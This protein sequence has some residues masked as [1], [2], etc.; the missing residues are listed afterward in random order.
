VADAR[1]AAGEAPGEA[2]VPARIIYATYGVGLTANSVAMMLKVV[3]PLWAIHLGLSATEIGMAVAASALLPFLLSIH[4]GVMMDRLGIR[5]VTLAY[6]VTTAVAAPFYPVLPFYST[7]ILLQLITG[8][9][10]NM[11]WVGGQ[12]LICT[13]TA[14]KTALLARFSVAGKVGTLAAPAAVGAAWDLGGPWGAFLFVTAAS[15][16]V[17][18]AVLLVPGA[19]ENAPR[20]SAAQVVRE[21]APKWTD[22]IR[23]F[24]L[25]AIP[26]VA[27]VVVMSALR[28]SSSAIQTSFY[29]VYLTEIGLIGTVIGLLV[30]ISEGAGLLGAFMA[31]FWE[32]YLKPHWVFILFVIMSIFCVSAT[33]ALGGLI[34][35]LAVATFG[36]GYAQGLSQPVMFGILSRAVGRSQQGTSIGLRTTSNRFA[37]LVVPAIMGIVADAVG[38][39][40]SFLWVG[41]VLIVLCLA[42]ALLVRRIPGFRT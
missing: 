27:F 40:A 14:G 24:S 12:S 9:T 41:G 39:E 8:L 31:G 25:I 17:V 35:L 11:G 42:V 34:V 5:R 4:G 16:L 21:L 37:S 2:P 13:F 23:A 32:R 7:I 19:A 33:P 30:G 29:V 6:V 15:W 28:I 20:P 22:Y 3:F 38:I 1:G 18:A 26:A 36:R 10:S